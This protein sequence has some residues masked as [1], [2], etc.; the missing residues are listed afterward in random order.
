LGSML[1][2][3][4]VAKTGGD[5]LFASMYADYEALSD[6]LKST[7]KGHKPLHSSRHVF[8]PGQRQ[9]A[10]TRLGRC[11]RPESLARRSNPIG[12]VLSSPQLLGSTRNGN[13]GGGSD[14]NPR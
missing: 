8:G 2:A 13:G 5:T 3:R 6:V 12:R 7:V 14:R 9:R 1:Y 11:H 4:E 10:G